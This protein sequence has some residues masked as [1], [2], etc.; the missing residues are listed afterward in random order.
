M[1]CPHCESTATTECAARTELGNHRFR[2][3]DCG[4]VFHERT[5]T[6]FNRLQ[7]P[8]FSG[9]SP[10]QGRL[11]LRIADKPQRFAQL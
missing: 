8:R 3:R 2:C 4:R 6:L 11:C 7:Y 9:R 5:G 10:C 1:T